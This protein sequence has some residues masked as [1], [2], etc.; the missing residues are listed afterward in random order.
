MPVLYYIFFQKQCYFWVKIKLA[1]SLWSVLNFST[2]NSYLRPIECI[3]NK[4]L[5]FQHKAT[6]PAKRSATEFKF[7][8]H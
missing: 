4:S 6:K 3:I 5:I 1:L 8:F 2:L 7:Q